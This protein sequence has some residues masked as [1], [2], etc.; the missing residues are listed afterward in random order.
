MSRKLRSVKNLFKEASIVRKRSLH[1]AK[2]ARTENA[3]MK[4]QLKNNVS[5][6]DNYYA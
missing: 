1:A 4:N 5:L 2:K 6:V 3:K